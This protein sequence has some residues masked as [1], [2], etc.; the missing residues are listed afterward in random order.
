MFT[1]NGDGSNDVFTVEGVNLESV[2][3]EI[4]NRWGQKM[5]AWDNVRGSWNGRTLAGSEAPDGTY[6]YI[7]K[8]KGFDGTDY[9]E[10]GGFS[11]IR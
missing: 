6:F 9:F 2:E 7:I 11:L 10:R 3:G 8:A 4:Y 5:F 1:P